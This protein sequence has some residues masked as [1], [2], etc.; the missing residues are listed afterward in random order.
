MHVTVV[1]PIAN[2][3]PDAGVHVVERLPS[4]RSVALVVNVTVAPLAPVASAVIGDGTVTTGTVVSE[5]VTLKEALAEL[6]RVSEALQFTVVVP[7]LKVLPD[8]GVQVTGRLPSTM[9]VAEV[10]N[11]TVTFAP[12]DSKVIELGTVSV[13][14]VVS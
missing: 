1:V 10:E 9:S 13:G 14:G 5:T 3:A 12:V 8:T 7:T 2:A 11:V 6:F 4:T